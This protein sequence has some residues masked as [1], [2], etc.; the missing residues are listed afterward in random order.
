MLD[1]EISVPWDLPGQDGSEPCGREGGRHEGGTFRELAVF[2]R[3]T[4]EPEL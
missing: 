2:A 4:D 3:T 1:R